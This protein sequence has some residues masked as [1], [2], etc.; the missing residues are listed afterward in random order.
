MTPVLVKYD[1]ADDLPDPLPLV[2]APGEPT[3]FP[4][5][6]LGP[7]LADAANAIADSTQCA[8]AT[9]AQSVLGAAALA[10]QAHADVR[11][12]HGQIRPLSLFLITVAGSGERK[13]A[14]D[15]LA[16]APVREDEDR[17]AITHRAQGIDYRN[18]HDAW[19]ASRAK[20]ERETKSSWSQKK[21]ALDLLGPEPKPPLRPELTV[22]NPTIEGLVK[23]WVD[24]RATRGLFTSEGGVFAAGVAMSD[25]NRLKTAATL[26]SLWDSGRADRD[27]AG[28]GVLRLK[29]RR[30]S[31]HLLIQ[32]DLSRRLLASADLTDQGLSSRLL[33]A[34]PKPMAGLRQFR[35]PQSDDPRLLA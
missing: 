29:G 5:D 34:A 2:R 16:L 31:M 9:A 28:D 25:D 15:D 26:S 20:I 24:G 7:V 11:L 23:N 1:P 13:S 12:P 33:V 8:P 27:R 19:R 6:A 18:A 35:K 4:T 22:T 10:V 21:E 3:A 32:P 14:A 17:A 30:L